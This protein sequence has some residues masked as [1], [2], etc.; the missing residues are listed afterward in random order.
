MPFKNDGRNPAGKLDTQ[1]RGTGIFYHAEI[2]CIKGN[3]L[4]VTLFTTVHNWVYTS[5]CKNCLCRELMDQVRMNLKV[6]GSRPNKT[7]TI[8]H[9]MLAS[10]FQ[11]FI[12]V[13]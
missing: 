1:E 6:L 10:R 2:P 12:N 11:V 5:G 9:S 4:S 7:Y 8:M 13:L 3:S